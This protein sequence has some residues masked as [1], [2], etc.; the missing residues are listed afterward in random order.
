MMGIFLNGCNTKRSLSP[1]TMQSAPPDNANSRYTLSLGSRQIL[2]EWF[3]ITS[4]DTSIYFLTNATL[5]LNRKYLPNLG[6]C[7]TLF[8]SFNVKY[9][10]KTTLSCLAFSKALSGVESLKKAALRRTLL[11]KITLNYS[12]FNNSS[13][14]SGDNPCL[15]AYT[16]I[17]SIISRSVRRSNNHKSIMRINSS[18]SPADSPSIFRAI[19]SFTS[20]CTV[21]IN[22]IFIKNT[23]SQRLV[24]E[25]HDNFLKNSRTTLLNHK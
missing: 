23:K 6:R 7:I 22:T 11:S 21:R 18:F 8:N 1:E 13:N 12:S 9:E 25:Q 19:S 10:R 3:T 5:S 16:L 20:N 2:T 15:W 24:Q 17:S 4:S 14:I